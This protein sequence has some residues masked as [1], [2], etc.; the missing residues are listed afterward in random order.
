MAMIDD[1]GLMEERRRAE[2]LRLRVVGYNAKEIGDRLDST[3]GGPLT[4]RQVDRVLRDIAEEQRAENEEL[5]AQLR[6]EQNERLEWLYAVCAKRIAEA[7]DEK[8][9][10]AAVL[11]LDR[12]SKLHGLDARGPTAAG[13]T[14]RDEE[15]IKKAPIDQVIKLGEQMGLT[16][17]GKF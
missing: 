1:Q 14:S 17:P 16:M 7:P 8:M 5:C 4:R 9:I 10:R 12:Q 11:V 3:F 2:I 6:T 13:S 15:W